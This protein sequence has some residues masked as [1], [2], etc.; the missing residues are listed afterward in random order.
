MTEKKSTIGKSL[1]SKD[2]SII[3]ISKSSNKNEMSS[4]RKSDRKNE[5]VYFENQNTKDIENK[6]KNYNKNEKK[7]S[8][9]NEEITK[10]EEK[11]NCEFNENKIIINDISEEEMKKYNQISFKIFEKKY[12]ENNEFIKDL[13]DL[14]EKTPIEVKFFTMLFSISIK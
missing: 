2:N 10:N 5:T 13:S 4:I 12:K 1:F 9:K 14:I 8:T 6:I 11:E 7:N 3:D